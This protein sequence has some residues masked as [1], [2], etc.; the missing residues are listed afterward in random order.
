MIH[1]CGSFPN[2]IKI[3]SVLIAKLQNNVIMANAIRHNLKGGTKDQELKNPD[4]FFFLI[5]IT[6]FF[7]SVQVILVCYGRQISV[8]PPLQ[9]KITLGGV[10]R[11]KK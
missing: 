5:S 10:Y 11:G 3:V 8:I 6:L 7:T 1:S 4:F 9:T 2:L